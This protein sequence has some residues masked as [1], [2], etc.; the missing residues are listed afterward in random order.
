SGGLLGAIGGA[1]VLSTS[2]G[3]HSG[4]IFAAWLTRC[5]RSRARNG[6][7]AL[8]PL[9]KSSQRTAL[10]G[11]TT[12]VHASPTAASAAAVRSGTDRVRSLATTAAKRAG[13]RAPVSDAAASDVAAPT[14]AR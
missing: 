7:S 13:M 5:V 2:H 14:R 8:P 3:F 6:T 4:G 1:F 10:R 9:L 11:Q 12:R